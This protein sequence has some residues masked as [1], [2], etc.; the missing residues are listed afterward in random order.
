LRKALL[1][2]SKRGHDLQRPDVRVSFDADEVDTDGPQARPRINDDALVELALERVCEALRPGDTI[3][4]HAATG[5]KK[6]AGK[7]ER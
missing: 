4:R 5:S 3:K 1:L 7:E 6:N 2:R